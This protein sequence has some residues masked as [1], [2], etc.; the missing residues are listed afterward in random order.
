MCFHSWSCSHGDKTS[1]F[2]VMGNLYQHTHT[3]ANIQREKCFCI[4]FFPISCYNKLLDTIH[5]NEMNDD[6]FVV[7][8][9]TVSNAKTIHALA[10]NEAFLTMECILKE[11]QDLSGTGIT[12][13]VIGKVQNISVEEAYAQGMN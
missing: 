1:F 7:E 9:F 2:A 4:N 10:I 5:Q 11:I 3:Y 12:A 13:M 6:E 8:G